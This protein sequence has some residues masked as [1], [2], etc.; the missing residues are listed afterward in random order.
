M[1]TTLFWITKNRHNSERKDKLRSIQTGEYNLSAANRIATDAMTGKKAEASCWVAG[2]ILQ[3][4]HLRDSLQ[5]THATW[6]G[7]EGRVEQ[8]KKKK[9]KIFLH[10]RTEMHCPRMQTRGP[11]LGVQFSPEPHQGFCKPR[12]E[13]E[14]LA[15]AALGVDHLAIFT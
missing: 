7:L 3:P 6:S 8:G 12:A 5:E 4:L 10:S 2:D 14:A 9:K 1:F 13:T 15:S 11:S